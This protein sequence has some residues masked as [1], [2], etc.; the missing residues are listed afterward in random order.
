MA[1]VGWAKYTRTCENSRRRDAKRVPKIRDYRQSQGF[2]PFT[3]EWFW[4][5]NLIS[6]YKTIT[7]NQ[8]NSFSW[9]LSC[10]CSCHRW[11][12][13]DVIAN[14]TV[15]IVYLDS[16]S[17]WPDGPWS[18]GKITASH[19]KEEMNIEFGISVDSKF[20]L[21]RSGPVISKALSSRRGHF[22]CLQKSHRKK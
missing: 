5:V 4:D 9:L 21:P 2:W 14:E 7:C 22:L 13:E 16:T 12:A 17:T 8:W 6:S 11:T 1:I 18:R 20:L 3:A 19:L 15:R 10:V